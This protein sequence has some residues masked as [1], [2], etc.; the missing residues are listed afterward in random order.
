MTLSQ[1]SVP[2]VAKVPE[3]E[4]ALF[5][6]LTHDLG[7]TPSNAIRMF[8]AAFNRRGAFPFDVSNPLGYGEETMVAM[9][10]VAQG[11]NVSGRFK[12]VEELFEDLD[13]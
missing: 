2:V 10:D 12:S 4:K 13:G 9:R 8:I 1:Q 7:T 3:S 6:Q 11:K 5:T